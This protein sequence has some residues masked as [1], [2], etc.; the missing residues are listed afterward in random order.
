[1][2]ATTTNVP[3]N[4]NEE[5]PRFMLIFGIIFII[6]GF[7][8]AIVVSKDTDPRVDKKT[9]VLSC[10]VLMAIGIGMVVAHVLKQKN[11]N[12]NPTPK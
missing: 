9:V 5:G 6:F 2:N 3:E 4:K 8:G 10:I 7:V 1:M 12:K 11:R